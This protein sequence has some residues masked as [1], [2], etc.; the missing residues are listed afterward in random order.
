VTCW[1][2]FGTFSIRFPIV[3]AEGNGDGEREILPRSGS[4][5]VKKLA[6]Q[7]QASVISARQFR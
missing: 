4:P 1:A 6:D 3:G 7:K 2:H 5:T